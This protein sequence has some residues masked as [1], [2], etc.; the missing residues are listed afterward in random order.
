MW[1]KTKLCPTAR[2]KRT[3]IRIA[4]NSNLI[5]RQIAEKAAVTTN[6]ANVRRLLKNCEHLK[7]GKSITKTLV[8]ARA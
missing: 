2:D 6:V 8:E 1:K 5:A 7:R 4:S 3:V